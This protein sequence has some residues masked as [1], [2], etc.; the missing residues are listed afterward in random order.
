MRVWCVANQNSG[1]GKTTTAIALAGLLT[2]KNK[3]VLL[4]DTDPHAS[5]TAYLNYDPANV[6]H[7]L[8][9]LFHLSNIDKKSLDKVIINTSFAGLDLLNAHISLATL[10]QVMG[11]KNGM[12]LV[13]KQALGRIEG[14]Y[15]FV[16]IDSPPVLG[17]MM[18]NA[19]VASDRILIPVPT[20]FLALKGL[21]RMLQT[22]RIMQKSQQARFNISIVPTMFDR[23]NRTSLETLQTLKARY[24]RQVWASVIPFDSKIRDASLQGVPPS[25]FAKGC[26]GVYAYK[27]LLPYLERLE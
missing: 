8:F 9:D 18:I 22:L 3:R 10:D 11:S 14:E 26:R 2:E 17:V 7:S 23:Q 25:L 21:E 20:N 12:G 6:T 1:A 24:D 15:D 13:L 4:V 19:L 16:L 27:M 5:L